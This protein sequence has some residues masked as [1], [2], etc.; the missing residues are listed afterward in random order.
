MTTSRALGRHTLADEG[1]TVII[2]CDGA[3]SHDEAVAIHTL[4]A[5]VLA[6]EGRCFALA[7]LSRMTSIAPT[8]R[9]YSM[10]WSKAHRVD[11]VAMI[12]ASFPLRV[13][14]TVTLEAVRLLRRRAIDLKFVDDESAGRAWIA[15]Q[16]ARRDPA[17]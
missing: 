15:T 13:L 3:M 1:D 16:R 8:A 17:A 11:A 4:L 10:E 2:R 14:T 9:R 12:G 7:D 6:R 5:E